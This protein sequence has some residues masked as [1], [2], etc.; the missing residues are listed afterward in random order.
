ME[1]TTSLDVMLIFDIVMIVL[2]I[3]MMAAS[4]KMKRTKE[5]GTMILAEE[6]VQKCKDK[7]GFATFFY[8]YELVM[9]IAFLLC[10]A[11]RLADKL[12]IKI[13]GAL[14]V[15]PIIVLLIVACW[16]YKGLQD[17][18]AKFLN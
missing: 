17:A 6:D 3:Y 18:K 12:L 16:F 4:L 15:V 9:G 11:V 1:G 7:A 10:G 14:D 13:G 2:G 5:I 8:S